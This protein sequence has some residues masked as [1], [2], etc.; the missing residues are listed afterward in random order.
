PKKLP[1]QPSFRHLTNNLQ[2]NDL[3]IEKTVEFYQ[4]ELRDDDDREK[5][6]KRAVCAKNWIGKYAPEEFKFSIN[7]TVSKVDVKFKALIEDVVKQLVKR[8]WTD[9]ELHE[10][11]YVLM[12]KH[13]IDNKDFFGLMYGVLIGKEKG[14]QLASFVLTIGRERVAALLKGAI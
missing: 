12:K 7:E 8:D 1:Y 5:L 14:P 10:E 3:D 11:F 2:I 4:N 9:K 6:R 13:D